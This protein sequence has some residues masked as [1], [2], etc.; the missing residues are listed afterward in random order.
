MS[1]DLRQDAEYIVTH[2]NAIRQILRRSTDVSIAESG[3]TAP[4]ISLLKA[5]VDSDGLTLKEL[6]ETLGLAH[7]TVSGIVDRL[8]RQH[9]VQRRPDPDDKR[10]TRIY[11][12]ERV[13]QF[14]TAT[15]RFQQL[16]PL[17]EALGRA[18][19]EERETIL[20]GL[21]ILQGLLEACSD[22]KME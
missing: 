15:Y 9:F 6:S 13:K 2:L 4:Q 10:Y 8:S 22:I 11:A 12:D 1:Q 19:D 17:L 16:Q 20:D 3:L 14:V 7:S 5:L 21:A 18:S